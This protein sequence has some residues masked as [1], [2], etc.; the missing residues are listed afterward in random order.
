MPPEVVADDHVDEPDEDPQGDTKTK[1]KV[2][3]YGLTPRT[4][5]STNT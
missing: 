4:G 5:V 1:G 3:H 2:L